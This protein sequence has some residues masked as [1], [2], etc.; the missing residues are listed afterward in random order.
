MPPNICAF[1]FRSFVIDKNSKNYDVCDQGRKWILCIHTHLYIIDCKLM[2][3]NS[4]SSLKVD[5]HFDT[6][7]YLQANQF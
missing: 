5:L 4:E 2:N 6:L 3:F 1:N 7:F